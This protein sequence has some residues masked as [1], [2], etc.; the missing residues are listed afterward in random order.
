[1]A[2]SE[3]IIF[4]P[5]YTPNKNWVKELDSRLMDA[6]LSSFLAPKNDNRV[7]TLCRPFAVLPK[8]SYSSPVTLPLGLAYLGA[9]LEKAGYKTKIIDATG[10]QKPVKIIRSKDNLY[11][12]QGLTSKEILEKI[13]PNTFIFG[14]SLMFSQEWPAHKLLIKEIKRKYPKI[15]IVAGGEHSS[16]IPEYVLND[17]P[18]VD[19]V[20]RGEGEFSMLEFSYNI[21]SKKSVNKISG[22]CFLDKENKFINNTKK[23]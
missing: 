14:I 20:I 13:D 2:P 19:Y 9:V 7:V 3:D 6:T 5:A 1:M 12:F 22:I 8:T 17:C 10:E 21:F 18:S 15:I 11:N 23:S 16:A 4:E